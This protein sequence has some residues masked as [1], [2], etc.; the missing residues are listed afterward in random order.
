METREAWLK[1]RFGRRGDVMARLLSLAAAPTFAV[2]ALV[3]AMAPDD[4]ICGAMQGSFS[5]QG[6]VPMYALMCAFHLA[7]WLR[8]F[9]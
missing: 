1:G 2:M 7:P 8:L 3:A 4:M 6:M 5:L 9:R